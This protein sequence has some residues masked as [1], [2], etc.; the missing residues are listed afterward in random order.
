VHAQKLPLFDA[1]SPCPVQHALPGNHQ[2]AAH[3]H[4]VQHCDRSRLIPRDS[5]NPTVEEPTTTNRTPQHSCWWTAA[6]RVT[7]ATPATCA[8]QPI[9]PANELRSEG[10]ALLHWFLTDSG[11]QA[12][13]NDCAN[14]HCVPSSYL[15]SSAS[16]SNS[17]FFIRQYP[18]KHTSDGNLL[19]LPL[20]CVAACTTPQQY[21]MLRQAPKPLVRKLQ[22]EA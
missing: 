7:A 3:S 14:Y 18:A 1:A 13:C 4:G 2:S 8:P 10:H 22:Q 17:Y 15:T 16:S 19:L 6:G 20:L 12:A 9:W 21:R 11:C 5:L